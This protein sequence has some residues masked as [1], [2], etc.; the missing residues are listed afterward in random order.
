MDIIQAYYQLVP[1][2][3]FICIFLGI[4]LKIKVKQTT[5]NNPSRIFSFTLT[6][7]ILAIT[8]LF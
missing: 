3:K 4:L 1:P 8:Y 5:H 6:Y 2:Q 7:L